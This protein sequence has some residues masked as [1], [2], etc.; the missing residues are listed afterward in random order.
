MNE[1]QLKIIELAS[2]KNIWS[3][4][5]RKIGGE[6]NEKNAGTVKY[7]LEQLL[8]KGL[9]KKP[10]DNKLKKL[11]EAINQ[12]QRSIVSIPI[13]GAANCGIA[14]LVAEEMLEGYLKVSPGMLPTRDYGSLFAIRAKGNS[15]NIANIDK[16]NVEEGDYLIIDT[17]LKPNND[18]YVLSIIEGCANIK[19]FRRE[20]DRII[21]ESESTEDIPPIFIHPD[22][23]YLIN[24]VVKVIKKPSV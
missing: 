1:K 17:G 10:E 20:H 18:D 24:G 5:L 12:A 2:R 19:K 14:T 7:H 8:K 23:N 4:T 22:D 21:L 9:L 15:L 13:L 16:Q 6:I 3:M 11:Q